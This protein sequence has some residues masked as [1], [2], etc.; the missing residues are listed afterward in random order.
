MNPAVGQRRVAQ[1]KFQKLEVYRLALEYLNRLYEIAKAFPLE[2]KYNLTSQL[3]RAGT[4]VVLNIAE[5][6]TGQ[7]DA[8]QQRFL[9][10]SLRSYLETVACLDIAEMRGYVLTA[11]LDETRALGHRLFMKLQAFRNS[12]KSPSAPSTNR[13]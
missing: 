5:G 3:I 10:M 2:E 13:A 11:D 9:G 1:Y 7:S 6:S 12:L 4:S 8:E